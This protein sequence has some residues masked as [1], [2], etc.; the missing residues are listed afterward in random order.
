M[1]QR[2]A[3]VDKTMEIMVHFSFNP[4]KRY[5][6]N[7]LVNTQTTSGIVNKC[8]ISNKT[9]VIEIG[10]GVGA[11]TQELAEK[12]FKVICFEIDDGI[13]VPLTYA[14]SDY[15]NVEI[16]NKDFLKINLDDYISSYLDREIIVVSNLPYYI[17][18]DI[19]ISLFP[20]K[21]ISKV[22]AMMQKEEAHRI[23]KSSGGKDE[24]KLTIFAKY[25]T[26]FEALMEISKNDFFPKPNID[27]TV[28]KFEFKHPKEVDP[29]KFGSVIDALF[30][31]RRKTVLNNLGKAVGKEKATKILGE[32]HISLDA[33]AEDLSVDQIV[34]IMKRI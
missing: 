21:H 25:F 3:T 24:N 13:I 26:E 31:Q 6:Q 14:L 17:T 5:G 4:K 33:R 12:A 30:L 20:N 10:P 32:V 34:E 8:N 19:L 23:L 11:L 15:K 28:M 7:F 1:N 2:I 9:I 29:N 18:S 16:I 27:S 22:V